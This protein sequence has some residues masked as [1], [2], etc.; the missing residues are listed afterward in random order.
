MQFEVKK[1]VPKSKDNVPIAMEQVEFLMH[2]DMC[3]NVQIAEET[4]KFGSNNDNIR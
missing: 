2:M 3:M 4:G 1:I